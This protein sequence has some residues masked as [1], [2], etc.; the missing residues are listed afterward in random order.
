MAR[1]HAKIADQRGDFLH[2]LSTRLVENDLIACES[3]AVV[4]MMKNRCLSRA[5]GQAGWGEFVRQLEY[6]AEWYGRTVARAE[7]F[8]PSSKRCSNCAAS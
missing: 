3:L 1:I 2:K 6:K 5:I 4:N 8:F 7:R